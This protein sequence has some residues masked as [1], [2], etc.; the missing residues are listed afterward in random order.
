M[1]YDTFMPD[2]SSIR[3]RNLNGEEVLNVVENGWEG[4][5]LH[6]TLPEGK[7]GFA[8]G[9]LAEIESDTALYLGEIR[10]CNGSAMKVLVEHSLNLSKLASMQDNW[11]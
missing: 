11:R 1:E 10:Q 5:L 8:P 6:L 3:L 2:R 4:N 9:V 7:T